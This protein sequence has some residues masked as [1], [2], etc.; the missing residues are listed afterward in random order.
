MA[1]RAI[2]R[3]TRHHQVTCRMPTT[4][5]QSDLMVSSSLL[6][7]GEL[8]AVVTVFLPIQRLQK[9]VSYRSVV[10]H[11]LECPIL[12]HS[13]T[14]ICQMTFPINLSILRRRLSC[15]L[16][17]IAIPLV[18][19]QLT[20]GHHAARTALRW[21]EFL[22][23]LHGVA[24]HAELL[25]I[26]DARHLSLWNTIT[27]ALL[28]HCRSLALSTLAARIAPVELKFRPRFFFATLATPVS[29]FHCYLRKSVVAYYYASNLE[30][31][32]R[33]E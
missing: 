12:E 28:F 3:M 26:L 9:L 23:R 16:R 21:R 13:D 8:K 30:C 20:V 11:T 25:P 15:L 18:E 17:R 6:R 19:A 32:T 10:R 1:L 33:R 27:P 4:L 24:R 14:M 31:Q 2:T 5:R 29:L 22:K 7:L